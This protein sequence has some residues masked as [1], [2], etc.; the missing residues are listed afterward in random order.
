[1]NKIL[2][3]ITLLLLGS[4]GC[5][6]TLHAQENATEVTTETSKV[7]YVYSMEEAQKLAY[8]KKKLIFVNCYAKWALP[9]VGMNQYVFGNQEFA[10]YMNK[11]FINLFVDMKSADGKK[12]AK[13]YNVHSYA[14]YLILNYKGEI[15][16]R[17]SGGSKL[18][19]FK[20]KVRI[21]LSPKTSLKGT[22]EKYESD[23]YSKKDLYN[24]LY[25]LNVAGEDSLFQK[26]GKEYMAMLS[27]KE[28]SEKKNWIFA[29]I[30]RDRKSLYYKYLV[31]HKDLFVKEN[32]EKA[33]DNYLSSLFSSEVLSLATE[34]TDYDAARMDKLEQEMKEASLPDTCLVSIVYGIG[35]LRGQ[36]KYHEMLQY[37]EKNE[38]YFAQQLGVRPLI[39]ASFY[40]PQLKGSEK[41]ELLT[42]LRKAASR[43][44]GAD[45][46]RLNKLIALMEEGYK[47]IEFDQLTFAELLKKAKDEGKLVFI[48]CYTS[49]CG[50]CRAMANSVF[51]KE[52]VGNYFNTRFINAKMDMEK[53][54]GKEV[55]K[56][57]KINAFPTLLFLDSDGNL[58]ERLIGYKSPEALLKAV[59]D[60]KAK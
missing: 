5:G 32:G 30:H 55:A 12:L 31:S 6:Y 52:E 22:R 21:A 58:I 38:R 13:E 28:Y 11:T 53:G 43:E 41:N 51:P 48:D 9:C 44:T 39:E 35:K 17:I 29:R 56:K 15:I 54:E 23:K 27:D 36:K 50:P 47:G 57:Y 33:V 16:Q 45:A 46:N 8:Q 2:T 10:E 14:H 40:F 59:S 7:N 18:P 24:Y 26:L 42:Y 4:M 34:D 1:M 49:W 3:I 20:D 37:I 25:A 19:E 60:I